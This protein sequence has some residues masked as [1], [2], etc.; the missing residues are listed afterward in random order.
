MAQGSLFKVCRHALGYSERQ[1]QLALCLPDR[2]TLRRI[3][4]DQIDVHGPTWIALWGIMDEAG[5]TELAGY[6]EGI[7]NSNRERL[8]QAAND[9]LDKRQR[10][11][12]ITNR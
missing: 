11:E 10:R 6:I 12:V 5:H 8:Q 3:E 4:M 1:M 9:E 7:I 2:R